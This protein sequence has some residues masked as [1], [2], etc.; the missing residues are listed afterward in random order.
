MKSLLLRRQR[1]HCLSPWRRDLA[2]KDFENQFN[3]QFV[4]LQQLIA[5]QKKQLLVLGEGEECSCDVRVA[6]RFSLFASRARV[7]Y[8]EFLPLELG[9]ANN[10]ILT[11]KRIL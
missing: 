9:F 5:I 10:P 8:H 4:W 2:V 1:N 6:F 3:K 11:R 7:F